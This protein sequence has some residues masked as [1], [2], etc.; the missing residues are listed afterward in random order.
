MFVLAVAGVVLG[1]ALLFLGL[2]G[3]RIDDH[4]LCSRCRFDLV[5][6]PVLSDGAGPAGAARCPECGADLSR[7]RATRTG[8]RRRFR[9]LIG[10]ASVVLLAGIGLAGAAGWGAATKF[11]WNTV[12]PTWWLKDEAQGPHAPKAAAAIL[13][14][15]ER[16]KK[17]RLGPASAAILIERGLALQADRDRIWIPEWGD[18]INAAGNQDLLTDEQRLAFARSSV[19][20]RVTIRSRLRRGEANAIE[21]HFWRNRTGRSAPIMLQPALVSAYLDGRPIAAPALTGRVSP[22]HGGASAIGNSIT[23]DAE[24][25]EHILK[26]IWSYSVLDAT[27]RRPS[28]PLEW[29]RTVETPITVLAE[30]AELVRL[31]KNESIRREM[32]AAIHADPIQLAPARD[33]RYSFNHQFTF[34]NLPADAAFDVIWC[35]GEREWTV[36]TISGTRGSGHHGRG[37]GGDAPDLDPAAT[38]VDI[39]LRPSL[40]AAARTTDILDIWDGEIILEDVPI[41]WPKKEP[42]GGP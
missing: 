29:Q 28:V 16:L 17:N 36:G 27:G 38:T 32:E 12:K 7:P 40:K 3:R 1:V 5:G 41:E 26:T 10:V 19:E 18:L 35:A 39:I 20:P 21:V 8:H 11:N 13:E 37:Y 6:L 42:G 24:P 25:G 4:P 22:R 33:G 23:I 34:R 30:D 31:V 2:R 9:L 15:T 14:L